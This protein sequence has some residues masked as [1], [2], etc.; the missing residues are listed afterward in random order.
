M[1]NMVFRR[2]SRIMTMLRPTSAKVRGGE[3]GRTPVVV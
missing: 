3:G 2:M 1:R